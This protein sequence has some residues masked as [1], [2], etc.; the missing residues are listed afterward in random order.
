MTEH[1]APS[2]SWLETGGHQSLDPFVAFAAAAGVTKTLALVTNLS[3]IPYRNPLLLAKSAAT[4]NRMSDG[5]FYMGAGA[6]YLKSEYFALGVDFSERNALFDE[7]LEV[8]TAPLERRTFR[9]RRH[10]F[11]GP[12]HPSP[13]RASQW[14]RPDLDGRQFGRRPAPGG[15]SFAAGWM[16]MTAPASVAKTARTP[17]GD[18]PEELNERLSTLKDYAGDRF[19]DM[20]LILGFSGASLANFERDAEQVRERMGELDAMGVDWTIIGAPWRRAPGTV[21]W[22][23]AFGETFLKKS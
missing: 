19:D 17:A 10:P 3:V 13:A 2:A 20:Q 12:Q 8:M 9:F 5:R 22:V 4:L 16:P 18:H 21:E 6:G 15:A 23:Q 1:P 11:L 7:A 14:R